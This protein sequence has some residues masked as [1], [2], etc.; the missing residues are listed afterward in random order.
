M[1]YLRVAV[2]G[3]KL[4]IAHWNFENIYSISWRIVSLDPVVC[5]HRNL[6]QPTFSAFLKYPDLT[7]LLHLALKAVTLTAK[8]HYNPG[9]KDTQKDWIKYYQKP[10][11]LSH[12]FQ[13]C[14]IC[15]GKLNIYC[16]LEALLASLV[17]EKKKKSKS[18][19]AW[20]SV[21]WHVPVLS[22][23]L[24]AAITLWQQNQLKLFSRK[25]TST[26]LNFPGF[27]L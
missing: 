2:V 24:A 15:S 9:E 18:G 22:L 4:L 6:L 21:A 17:K 26:A 3:V 14:L 16:K 5:F 1:L 12:I 10:I 27:R 7:S 23:R 19:I 25:A 11:Y 13:I 20:V 8:N